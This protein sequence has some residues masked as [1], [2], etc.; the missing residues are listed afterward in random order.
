MIP[1]HNRLQISI[2]TPCHENWHNMTV[3]D[4]GRFCASCQKNVIDF[5]QS[6]DRHIA[7]VFKKDGDVCGRFLRSQLERDLILPKEKNRLWMAA[8]A[9]VVAF[10]GLGKGKVFAQTVKT[11]TVQVEKQKKFD[12]PTCIAGNRKIKG[13][14]L[15]ETGTGLPG[16]NVNIVDRP[17]KE[18]QTDFDGIFT[19]EAEAGNILEFTMVGFETQRI[20]IDT[21][22]DKIEVTMNVYYDLMGDIVIIQNRNFAGRILYRI[23]NIFRK[24]DN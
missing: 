22:T 13:I 3:A 5:T 15:D 6:S 11:E 17:S 16:V 1:M 12:T 4:K 20:A 24:K 14:V 2:P 10:L 7:E 9:A 21:A 23:G 8:S 18:I 19:I